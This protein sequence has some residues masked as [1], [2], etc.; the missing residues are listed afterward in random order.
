MGQKHLVRQEL[1]PDG[2]VRVELSYAPD[3]VQD[4][5]A[6]TYYQNGQLSSEINYCNNR[7][8]GPVTVYF[9]DGSI[10]AEFSYLENKR[11]GS[12]SSYYQKRSARSRG[13]L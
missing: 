12:Y 4:G 9:E 3:G 7:M 2:K 10:R 6:K 8:E 13:E 1:F 11:H 5:P